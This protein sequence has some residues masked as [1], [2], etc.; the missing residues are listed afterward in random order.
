MNFIITALLENSLQFM[1]FSI[2]N[3]TDPDDVKTSSEY[4]SFVFSS[5]ILLSIL[6]VVALN[7][8]LVHTES[9]HNPRVLALFENLKLTSKPA[10]LYQ[11]VYIVRRLLVVLPLIFMRDFPLFQIVLQSLWSLGFAA[12]IA[13]IKPFD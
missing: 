5:V 3:M 13:I 9:I 1:M 6:A 12:Y 4:F 7:I 11:T 10:L 2:I 8:R